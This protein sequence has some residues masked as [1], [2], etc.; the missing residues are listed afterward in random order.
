MRWPAVKWFVPSW[1]LAV[2][3]ASA[4]RAEEGSVFAKRATVKLSTEPSRPGSPGQHAIGALVFSPDGRTLAAGG[5]RSNGWGRCTGE[6]KLW[7]MSTGK[8]E[9]YLQTLPRRVLKLAFSPDGKV[10][11]IGDGDYDEV[12]VVTLVDRR[13]GKTIKILTSSRSEPTWTYGLAFFPDGTRLV[14]CTASWMSDQE[15]GWRRGEVRLWEITSGRSRPISNWDEGPYQALAVAPDG[16][17]IAAG[18]G[19]CVDDSVY[20]E[21]AIRRF[22]ADPEHYRIS[23]RDL[24]RDLDSGEVR[25]WDVA[26]GRLRNKLAGHGS[27]VE[28]LAF[29]WDG[30]MLVSG[31]MDGVVKAWDP[32]NGREQ[33]TLKPTEKAGRG[34]RALDLAFSPDGRTLAIAFGDW[35]RWNRFGQVQFWDMPSRG[36]RQILYERSRYPINCVAFSPDGSLFAAV[37]DGDVVEI[38][39]VRR[40]GRSAP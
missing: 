37:T 18:G 2:L 29:S 4:S 35:T 40:P 33:F 14:R 12:G 8:E 32:G 34:G 5:E 7:S 22:Q 15:W 3:L 10:L 25:M 20:A 1:V 19:I 11:A 21:R 39:D 31:D 17:M 26:S 9:L 36:V 38:W 28:S 13:S 16:S 23:A 30:R 6:V 27:I 24:V